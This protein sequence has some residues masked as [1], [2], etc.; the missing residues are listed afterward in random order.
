MLQ[1]LQYTIMV[2]NALRDAPMALT[3]LKL[4][5]LLASSAA[6]S[7]QHAHKLP[8]TVPNAQAGSS[9]TSSA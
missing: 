5:W 8:A 7:A 9:T 4:T 3:F 1:L 6:T 2:Q